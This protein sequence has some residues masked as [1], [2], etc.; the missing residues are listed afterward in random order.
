MNRIFTLIFWWLSITLYGQFDPTLATA[1]YCN[2]E[3]QGTTLT[4]CHNLVSSGYCGSATYNQYTGPEK[5]YTFRITSPQ[6]INIKMVEF[7]EDLDIFLLRSCTPS[8]CVAE[9]SNPL[10]SGYEHIGTYLDT[11]TYYL[12]VDGWSNAASDFRMAFSCENS[13]GIPLCSQA[14]PLACN[15]TVTGNTN[16][17][18]NQIQGPYCNQFNN[19]SGKEK[20]YKIEVLNHTLVTINAKNFT[21]DLDLFLLNACSR[22]ACKAYSGKSGV[23]AESITAALDPGTYYIVLDGYLGISSPYTLSYTCQQNVA[24]LNC[25][26]AISTSYSGDGSTLRFN[27][28]FSAPS[29]YTFLRWK[30]NTTI[31]STNPDVH[32]LFNAAG[33]YNICA[34][35]QEV[36]TGLVKSCCKQSCISL[37]TTCESIIQYTYVNGI[38]KLSLAGSASSY[39]NVI[40]KNDTDGYAL[41]PNNVPASC[42]NILVT[43][44]YFNTATNCWSLCCRNIN[45]CPPASCQDNINYQ[46]ISSSNSFQ[47][48]FNVPYATNL[49]WR[50]DDTNTILPYGTLNMYPGYQCGEKTISVYYYDTYSKCWRVCC[51]K[52]Y[53]CPPV[54]CDQSISMTYN[55]SQ[56][57][58]QFS[59]NLAGNPSIIWKIEETNTYLTN[60]LF[61]LPTGWTC[62]ERT[63]SAYY[64]D[65]Q[66]QCWRIC[67]KKVS[68]C[69]P[70]Q[71]T[72]NI[73]FVYLQTGQFKFTLNSS[74]AQNIVWKFDATGTII[75]NGIFTLPY[76]WT[77]Q[78][79]SVSAYYYDPSTTSWR[80]C[81]K[82]IMLCPPTTCEDNIQYVYN[83]STNSFNFTFS[84]YSN[85][86]WKFDETG[87]ILPNGVFTLPYG[88][89]CQ[90]KVVTV[91]YLDPATQCYRACCK[92]VSL[93]PPTSCENAISH[94]YSADGNTLY[95]T[96]NVGS[97]QYLQWWVEETSQM[98]GG[99][100]NISFPANGSCHIRTFSIQYK[101]NGVWKMC[102]KKIN[103]CNPN[104]CGTTI[105][106]TNN[107]SYVTATVPS[108]LQNVV[109][110]SANSNNQIGSGHS[111][112]LPLVNQQIN[113]TVGVQFYNP[114]I[115]AYDA[116]YKNIVVACNAPV[117]NFTFQVNNNL[118]TFT[119]TS[120]NATSY[121]WNIGNGSFTQNCDPNTLHPTAI[122][123]SGTHQVCLTATNQCGSTKICY[124][125]IIQTG[126]DCT[127][128]IP[129]DVCGRAG[130]EILIP[131]VV[132][133]FNNVLTFNFTIRSSNPT[134]L[135]FLGIEQ[136]NSNIENGSNHYLL[137]DHVRFFW[138][139]ANAKTLPDQT[140]LFYIRCKFSQTVVGNVDIHF[141]NDPVKAEAYGGN[142]QKLNLELINGSACFNN[143]PLIYTLN[144][145]VMT[146]TLLKP[147]PNTN[148]AINNPNN[149]STMTNIDGQYGFSSVIA[150]SNVDIDPSSNV[151]HDAGVNALDIVRLQRHLL[152]VDPITSPY[153]LIAAD[154][155]NDKVVNAIDVVTLQRMQLKLID[156]F[157]NNTSHRF[158]PM[159]YV[160]VGDP[161]TSNFPEQISLQ[162]ISANVN[163]AD[164]YGIKIGDLDDS[165][166]PT[167][168]IVNR[169]P[170]AR[171]TV[172]VVM[173]P[174]Y[175]LKGTDIIIP[176]SVKNFRNLVALEGTIQWD[177]TKMSFV[178]ADDFALAGLN[179]ENFGIPT[180]IR[181]DVVTFSW[182][183]GNLAGISKDDDDVI[184]N[185]YFKS[186]MNEGE[187]SQLSFIQQPLKSYAAN[188]NLDDVFV[189]TSTNPVSIVAP[190]NVTHQ[191]NQ[192]LCHNTADGNVNVDVN[193]GT[194]QYQ[195]NWSDASLSGF[196]ISTLSNGNYAYTVTDALA[197]F[198]KDGSFT[199]QSP[200]P[201]EV[202]HG[203]TEDTDGFKITLIASGGTA[204]YTY[205]LDNVVISDQL[206]VSETGEY[207]FVI[208]DANNCSIKHS[209]SIT[210]VNT[211][212]TNAKYLV[213]LYPVPAQD[214]LYI[215]SNTVN[216]YGKAYEVIALDGRSVQS[217][218]I[219]ANSIPLDGIISGTFILKLSADNQIINKKFVIIK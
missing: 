97:A 62:Q 114:S 148:V 20:M 179:E 162:N 125:V 155:N 2:S 82:N 11:G 186:L 140:A 172:T 173:K 36:A 17:G 112:Q 152:V 113:T 45:F 66:I 211:D 27:Y 61:V 166:Q 122:F 78:Q 48:S 34:E 206:S 1:I 119:N 151:P 157:P 128:Q 160:F 86:I 215:K 100:T 96:A 169:N 69:P 24:P 19:Y 176:V 168:N 135:Q 195:I 108:N 75:P 171:D 85:L 8:D 209:V 14:L 207:Q 102:C 144:G 167:T 147:M 39:Q 180:H 77:C 187:T 7:T 68:I 192:P 67:C 87:Q 90:E 212:D 133:K 21:A 184:F 28:R 98:L 29:G 141:S 165:Y 93:C 42:R 71:C 131:V 193:G 91:Y 164:F 37:P 191:V 115:G 127:F 123:P 217:G 94:H 137:N 46:Y 201:L 194:G 15:Q 3:I 70:Q 121:H 33:T 175:S 129:T 79:K 136:M 74:N 198:V 56:N 83:A 116:C 25:N 95:L 41:D 142:L 181:K 189:N 218:K 183:T 55:P 196:D 104:Q 109:W 188:A 4:G 50:V 199:M 130:D 153:K 105:S 22:N 40:W 197:G 76:G 99:N 182:T 23:N 178:K 89:T 117:A 205:Y 9:S 159:S 73:E 149:T 111:L 49:T 103:V 53:I 44:T 118:V 208:V 58:F 150:A 5:L 57:A 106:T 185:M 65:P 138:S 216:L 64:F 120:T 47:F 145:Q 88:W 132:Q 72:G 210:T 154:V 203:V 174:V 214:I 13:A 143:T 110:Y 31:L 38:Y 170:A 146:H 161:L 139:N 190:L 101:E 54:T 32:L 81:T 80:I 52:V 18:I 84:G 177:T 156:V 12:V 204:P 202:T 107:S 200:A 163:N 126:Y 30:H 35:Y 158:V 10:S 219:E 213:N 6:N 134:D 16:T 60:G 124:D 59:M 92:K 26:D 51:R 63:V 43:V